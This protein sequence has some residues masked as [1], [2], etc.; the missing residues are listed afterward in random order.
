MISATQARALVVAK[1]T[2]LFAR[3]YYRI[4]DEYHQ[5]PELSEADLREVTLRD[6]GWDVRC[7]PLAGLYVIGRVAK[8]GSWVDLDRVGVANQ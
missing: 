6:D 2:R 8:D 7:D 5:F 3:A 1:Y 4:D